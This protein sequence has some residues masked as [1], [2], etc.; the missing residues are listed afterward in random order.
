MCGKLNPS[1]DNLYKFTDYETGLKE[2]GCFSIFCCC[3]E[4]SNNYKIQRLFEKKINREEA[5]KKLTIENESCTLILRIFNFI[6]H[7]ASYYLILYPFILIIGM[8]PFFGAIGATILVFVAF[9]L[10][11]ITYLFIIAIAWVFARP[12]V[13]ILLLS[14]IFM[15]IFLVKL[16]KEHVYTTPNNEQHYDDNR[17]FNHRVVF[18]EVNF[19]QY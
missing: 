10:S 7:F 14:I 9:L 2:A 19:L 3:S 17:G 12:L 16:T 15:L 5:I 1:E 6:L 13:G 8:I 4:S 18:E 11:S